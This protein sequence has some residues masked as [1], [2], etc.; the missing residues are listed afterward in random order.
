MEDLVQ[1]IRFA[2]RTFVRR[3]VFTVVALL[4]LVLG[5]GATTS[6][7]S[8][9]NG[10]L[11]SPFPYPDA[12]RLVVFWNTN[13]ERGQ[14]EDRMAA[15][16]F[17]EFQRSATSFS[18]MTLLAGATGTITGDDLPPTRVD[19]GLVSA[20]FFEVLGIKPLMGRTFRTEENQGQHRVIVLSHALW[21]GRFAGA[22]DLVG[23]RVT[24]DGET[25]EVVGVMP[26]VSLPTGGSS[27]HLPGPEEQ[28]YWMPLDYTLNWVA[29]TR[30]H[31]MAVVAR[32]RPGV[33]QAQAQDEMSTLA[34][35][36]EESGG[37]PGM[38]VIVRSL[39]EQVVGDIRHNLVILMAAVGLLL[40]MASGNLANLLLGRAADRKKELALRTA[41]G[42][43]RFRLVRQILTEVLLLS[44]VGGL[45]GLG[46]ARWASGAL[47]SLVPSSLPRQSQVGVD[48]TVFLFTIGTILIATLVAGVVPSL[49]AAGGEAGH[50]LREGARGGITGRGQARTSR[51]IVVSQLGLAA[52]LLVGAGLLLRSFQALKSVDLGFSTEEMLTAQLMLP[53]ARYQD[54][55]P[56]LGFFDRLEEQVASLPGVT[57]VVLAMDHPLENTWW[58]GI[59]FPNGPPPE[60]GQIPTGIFRPVSRGYFSALGI[61]VLEGREFDSGDGY[62]R[63]GVMVVNQAFAQ[64]YFP[65]E[66]VLGEQ[67]RFT[68]GRFIWGS[69]ANTVFEVVGVVGDVRFNGLREAPEPAFYIPMHQFPYQAV[70]V[71]VGT[72]SDPDALARAIQAEVWGLDPDLPIT[73]VWSLDRILAT[74][75]AQDRFNA[76][77]LG[78]FALA[79]LAL[80]AAGIYGVLSHAVSQ[81]TNEMGVRMAMGAHPGSVMSLVVRDAGVMAG[82]GLAGGLLASAGLSRFL[83]SLLFGVPPND[84]MILL[85]VGLI[86]GLVAVAS[87]FVPAIR[88]ARTD[89]MEALRAE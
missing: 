84:P 78:A 75:L 68:V 58:N 45:V 3:P 9:V 67:V 43:G 86:L 51:F 25:V 48:G 38:G 30:A 27:L 47:L 83:A 70:R 36:L 10:V 82:L 66:S 69:D 15:Q 7:F 6:I 5:I 42:A 32:M 31:V 64:R 12:D 29:E 34:R 2:L 62:D 4:T 41:L 72:S 39:R 73:E 44:S 63:H 80:A 37:Q 52:I 40:L 61:P 21:R 23:K 22:P 59:S 60:Q 20:N 77:L 19:G 87:G 16:D 11:L 79:A 8:V 14:D 65:G 54:A 56:T 85:G 17:F 33:S 50:G 81:R 88:A 57:S 76:L 18:G 1:D 26:R 74:E 28:I 46:L 55:G 49:Q 24:M 35:A 89:P 13:P 71:M 53:D